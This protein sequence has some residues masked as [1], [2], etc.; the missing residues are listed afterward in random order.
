M[1]IKEDNLIEQLRRKN[2]KA[3]EYVVDEYGGLL[4]SI[5]ASILGAYNDQGMIEECLD[6]VFMSI[7]NN[8]LKFSG[9]IPKFKSWAAAVAKYKALDYRRKYNKNLLNE[10]IEE[11]I[12][13]A[14]DSV[15][16]E[17]IFQEDKKELMKVIDELPQPDKSIFIKKYFLEESSEEI[18]QQLSLTRGAVDNRLSRGRKKLKEKLVLLKLQA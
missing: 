4:H 15:E 1:R 17:I 18:A 9:D 13:A 6:D 10:D 2:P 11:C 3:L 5:T 12:I 7:W 16:E 8:I 14:G